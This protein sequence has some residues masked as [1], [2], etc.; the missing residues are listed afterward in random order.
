[1]KTSAVVLCLLLNVSDPVEAHRIGI[2]IQQDLSQEFISDQ[3]REIASRGPE[4]GNLQHK[5]EKLESI[6][7]RLDN[8]IN[9][10]DEVLKPVPTSK[11]PP[12]P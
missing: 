1:M 11:E 5:L 4:M 3:L 8:A 12:A 7:P 9:A 2:D 10:I 6:R